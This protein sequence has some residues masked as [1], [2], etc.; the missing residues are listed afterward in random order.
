[1]ST[2]VS[3]KSSVAGK[4]P[5]ATDL[6]IG[7]LAVNLA[8]KKLFSKD[9]AG[10]VI[11]LG[12]TTDDVAAVSTKRLNKDYNGVYTTIEYRRQDNTL[13]S[14]SDL[15]GGVSPEYTTRTV[16]DF[17]ADGVTVTKTQVY[18]LVYSGGDLISENL[19]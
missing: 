6:Q 11:A 15:S 2:I 19:V 17:A 3:K 14:S 4:V 18:S 13:S 10:N 1:M 16:K 12:G 7:E 8:D 9:A 5:V